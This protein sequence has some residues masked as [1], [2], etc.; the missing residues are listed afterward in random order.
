MLWCEMAPEDYEESSEVGRVVG[1]S[2]DDNEDG[3]GSEISEEGETSEDE[4]AGLE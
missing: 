3:E 4:N 1:D 2:D